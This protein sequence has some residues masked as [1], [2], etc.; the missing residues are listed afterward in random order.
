MAGILVVAEHRSGEIR[1]ITFELITA[2]KNLKDKITGKLQVTVI[3]RDPSRYVEAINREGVD[4]II[5]VTV[6]DDEFNVEEQQH[7]VE[8][9]IKAVSPTLIFLGNTINSL[10]YGPALA[11][12][13]DVGFASD[14][15]RVNY[16]GDSFTAT[17]QY[18]GGK[19]NVELEFPGKSQYLI[20]IRAGSYPPAA[21]P[22]KAEV[23]NVDPQVDYSQIRVK[24]LTIQKP[25]AADVDITKAPFLLSIGRGVVKKENIPKFEQ[26]AAKIGATLSCSRPL[27]DAGWLP[28]SRQVGQSGKT[29]KPKIYLALGIS[30]A[31]QHQMGI[32]GSSTIIAVNTDADAPIFNIADYA[33]VC[34]MFALAEELAKQF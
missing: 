13:L 8:S 1:D 23:R 29:V 25:A 11:A 24:H 22:G 21:G 12:R 20:Q 19:V 2:A 5:T 10:S 30:G 16:E 3:A 18:Y 28:N 9:L 31:V 34:D 33:A 17:R 26:L 15:I 14:V 6:Q 7:V 32:K 4:E 27:V